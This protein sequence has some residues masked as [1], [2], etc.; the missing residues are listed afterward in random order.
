MKTSIL[1]LSLLLTPL[2]WAAEEAETEKPKSPFKASAELGALFKT[3]DTESGDLKAGFDLDYEEGRWIS[4]LRTDVLIRKLEEEDENGDTSYETSDQKWSIASQTNYKLEEG[5]QNYI[6]G[7][8]YYEDDRFSSFDSQSSVS[9]G[10]GRLWYETDKASL[11][12]DIG[13][14]Y[15]RDEVKATDT[16]KAETKDSIIAQAQALYKRKLNEHVEFKQYFVAKYAL[17]NGENSVYQAE[18]SITTKLIETLQL[19]FSYKIDHNTE[20]DEDKEN[21]NT[22]TS[23]TFVYSF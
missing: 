10:W 1:L 4:L 14:G 20:V 13:P 21:T 9:A 11:Y 2:A 3:G 18:T 19:K 6:Y 7:N 15:K 22:E 17:E 12:A 5:G 23:V 16:E 8:L